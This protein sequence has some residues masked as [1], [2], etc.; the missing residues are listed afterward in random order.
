ME[1]TNEEKC[2]YCR[3]YGNLP[4][5]ECN[6]KLEEKNAMNKYMPFINIPNVKMKSSKLKPMNK[7]KFTKV[8][9]S[10]RLPEEIDTNTVFLTKEG[11]VRIFYNK[12]YLKDYEPNYEEDDAEYFLEESPDR[13]DEMI[14]MLEGCKKSL[15][16]VYENWKYP[17]YFDEDGKE[18]HEAIE[19]V[20]YRRQ[21]LDKLVESLKQE[22]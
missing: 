22:K 16:F 2:T 9:V 18:E 8:A 17:M 6:K 3:G 15:D 19:H 5:D 11:N 7:T 1:L 20:L 4:C 13:E 21:E 10:E 14:E 12:K